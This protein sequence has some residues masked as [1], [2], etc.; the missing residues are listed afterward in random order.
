MTKPTFQCDYTGEKT[1]LWETIM[2]NQPSKVT[3]HVR[4]WIMGDYHMQPTF[5]SG[6]SG[7]KTRQ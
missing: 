3:M 1:G 6:Y 4:N 7:E 2:C 5:Q